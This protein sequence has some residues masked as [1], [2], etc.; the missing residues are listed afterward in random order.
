MD[1]SSGS[2]ADHGAPDRHQIPLHGLDVEYQVVDG[3][4]WIT[5]L[6]SVK[7]FFFLFFFLLDHAVGKY[8]SVYQECID[9]QY[10]TR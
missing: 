4:R 6:C 5:Y 8:L 9:N 7:Y 3:V 1:I 10:W 2:K